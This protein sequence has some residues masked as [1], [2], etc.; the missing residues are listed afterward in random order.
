MLLAAALSKLDRAD[1]AGAAAARV[2]ALQPGFRY[3]RHFLGVNCAPP[4]AIALGDA[5]Q[6]AG[7]P[8]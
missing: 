8:A 7:L 1:E 4:L 2:L 3:S 5:L 6:S